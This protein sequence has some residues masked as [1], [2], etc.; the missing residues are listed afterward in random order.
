MSIGI[1]H[2]FHFKDLNYAVDEIHRMCYFHPYK[3][4]SACRSNDRRGNANLHLENW[5]TLKDR[6]DYKKI[7]EKE[8]EAD[9]S[10]TKS[11]QLPFYS[12]S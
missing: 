11:I 4:I 8:Y 5:A 10:F 12:L 3:P 2:R 7:D 9:S 6:Q 1:N